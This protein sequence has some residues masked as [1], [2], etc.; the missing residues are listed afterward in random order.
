MRGW[1]HAESIRLERN[2]VDLGM[3]EDLRISMNMPSY[4]NFL[5]QEPLPPAVGHLQFSGSW[6][7]SPCG[8]T[9][10]KVY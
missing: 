1:W 2:I 5:L 9:G 8:T 7:R 4:L 10:H 6:A 3:V